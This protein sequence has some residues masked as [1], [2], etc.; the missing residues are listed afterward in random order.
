MKTYYVLALPRVLVL[1]H[2]VSQVFWKSGVCLL[3]RNFLLLT[4]GPGVALLPPLGWG[5]Q[6]PQP[7]FLWEALARL[8]LSSLCPS[9]TEML[10]S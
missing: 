4:L 6:S 10:Y 7:P 3:I 5:V 8:S 2:R 9:G 1:R